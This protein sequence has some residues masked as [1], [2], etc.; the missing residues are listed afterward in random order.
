VTLSWDP[1]SVSNGNI[2]SYAIYMSHDIFP[3]QDDQQ[4][5]YV[6]VR[7]HYKMCF[8]ISHRHVLYTETQD[9]IITY[10]IYSMYKYAVL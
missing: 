7:S 9:T 5:K 10:S 3:D 4:L 8:G 6:T 1:P 2:W